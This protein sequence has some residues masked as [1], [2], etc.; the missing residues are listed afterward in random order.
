M[1]IAQQSKEDGIIS[2]WHDKRDFLILSTM[3]ILW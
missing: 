2:K 3:M 1:I